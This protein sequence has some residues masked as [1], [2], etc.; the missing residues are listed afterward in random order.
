[1]LSASV[2]PILDDFLIVVSAGL[3]CKTFTSTCAACAGSPKALQGNEVQPLLQKVYGQ[4]LQE[5]LQLESTRPRH[6]EGSIVPQVGVVADLG[7]RLQLQ[8]YEEM[9][10]KT[11][12]GLFTLQRGR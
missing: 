6:R 12:K 4:A 2:W 3:S 9:A 11:L 10:V 8:G 5:R 1:M 7:M